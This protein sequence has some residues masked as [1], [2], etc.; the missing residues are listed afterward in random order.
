MDNNNEDKFSGLAEIY[1]RYRPSYPDE[2]IDYLYSEAGFAP[3]STIADIGAGTGRLSRLMAKRGSRV[4]LVEVNGEM[5]AA[6]RR[7]AEG[8]PNCGFVLAAA[9]NTG[10]P[11]NSADFVTVAQAFHWFDRAEAKAEFRRILKPGGKVVLVWNDRATK[12]GLDEETYETNRRYCPDFKGFSGGRHDR[13]DY[14]DFF[15]G[16]CDRRSFANQTVWDKESFI[17]EHLTASYA[18]RAGA[19]NYD[20]YVGTL[21]DIFDRYAKDGTL[22]NHMLT[23]SYCGGV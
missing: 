6:A 18:P 10:L 12:N 3:E 20:G 5:L 11:D 4:I 19:E 13:G 21:N 15:E 2:F 23:V 8:L 1:E 17:R 9:E 14:A 16:G 7:A 22:I